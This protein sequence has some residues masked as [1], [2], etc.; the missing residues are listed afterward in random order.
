MSRSG[1]VFHVAMTGAAATFV[2]GYTALYG[3]LLWTLGRGVIEFWA[4]SN[5]PG[6][7]GCAFALMFFICLKIAVWAGIA[8]TAKEADQ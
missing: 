4:E 5:F 6:M 8:S 3:F 7:V 1:I 2:L